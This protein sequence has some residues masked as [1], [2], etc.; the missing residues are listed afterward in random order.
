MLITAIEPRKKGLSALYIDGEFAIKIDTETLIIHHFDIGNE[1]N[2]EQLREVILASNIKRCKD[3]AM[4]LIEFRDHSRK[5]LIDKLK[6]DYPEDIAIST[7]DKLESLGLINDKNYAIKYSLD[8]INLKRLSK[9]GTKQKLISKGINKETIEDVLS[10]IDLDEKDQITN[11]LN[12]KYSKVLGTQKGNQ[13]AFNG[14]LRMGYNYQDIK[15]CMKEYLKEI[16]D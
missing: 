5:E 16:E 6:R 13:R 11:I 10:S 7:V 15:S 4:Y 2:D 12:K 14:L 3:K 9:N 1:I 8:L